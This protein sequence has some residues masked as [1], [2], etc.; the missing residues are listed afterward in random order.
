MN[1]D[2][3]S[4]S[5]KRYLIVPAVLFLLFI[6]LVFVFPGLDQ[7]LDLRGGTLLVVKADKPVQKESLV[8][9]LN[10]S[11]S[12]SGL[13]V[14]TTTGATGFGANIEFTENKVLAEAETLL[15]SAKESGNRQQAEQAL[16]LVADYAVPE[17]SPQDNELF[18]KEADKTLEKAREGFNSAMQSL[19]VKELGL[20]GEIAFQRKEIGPALG[21]S[22]WETASVV[23]ITAAVLVIVIIFIFFREVVPS[24][25]VI[26][27]AVFDIGC[28]L[29]LMAFFNISLSLSS[30]PALLMLVGY[31]VDTDIMLTTRILRRKEGT[32]AERTSEAMKTGLTM[33]FTT[34]A[35]LSVM[36]L[37]SYTSQMFVV[38]EISAV[39]LFG[40]VGDL[41]STWMM[42][43]PILLWYAEK[44]EKLRQKVM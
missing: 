19:I 1:L 11:F 28:A 33:T 41:P 26:L 31:S 37:V 38:F 2:L 21:K 44:K 40:L 25:A 30:I 10:E 7:G 29:A 35:A 14:S 20:S 8:K 32:P 17:S 43:A 3:Y 34:L 6:G 16:A 15:K 24:I 27:S 5:Y 42:N 23:G 18:F 36:L 4:G 13:V 22:F 39:L 9:T 12:L